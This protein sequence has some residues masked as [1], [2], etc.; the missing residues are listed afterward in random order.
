MEKCTR[1]NKKNFTL[2]HTGTTPSKLWS[3]QWRPRE[4]YIPWHCLLL[5]RHWIKIMR[6]KCWMVV[7]SLRRLESVFSLEGA[8]R[9]SK[10]KSWW[11]MT[12]FVTWGEKSSGKNL[13]EILANAAGCGIMRTSSCHWQV[14]WW[15]SIFWISPSMSLWKDYIHWNRSH[16]DFKKHSYRSGNR[17]NWRNHVEFARINCSAS[18][19]WSFCEDESIKTTP[20]QNIHIS[21]ENMECFLKSWDGFAGTNFL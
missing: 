10:M 3:T 12:C 19:C 13:L 4:G 18:E 9:K 21:T 17:R 16:I 14:T 20:T 1:E 15:V 7:V 5:R 11:C 8:S 6:S 2:P